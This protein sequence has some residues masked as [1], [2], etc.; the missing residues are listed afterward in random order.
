MNKT[1]K[2]EERKAAIERA[3]KVT[4]R[5][6]QL[7][8]RLEQE[9]RQSDEERLR[10]VY[11]EEKI[12][13]P[14]NLEA[15]C[16]LYHARPISCRMYGLAGSCGDKPQVFEDLIQQSKLSEHEAELDMVHQ[17]LHRL[18]RNV[19]HALTSILP[20]DNGPTF[21]LPSTVAG[22]FVQEYFQWISTAGIES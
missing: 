19:L 13:C 10:I 16:I 2:T 14:L 22:K 7:R 11:E 18:S 9:G 12:R 4:N 21:T 8:R 15:K 20:R 1:L 6:Q 3:I 5:V 17:L